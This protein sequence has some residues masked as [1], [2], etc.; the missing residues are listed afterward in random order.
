[1]TVMSRTVR[2]QPVTRE[3]VRRVAQWLDDPDVADSWYGKNLDG[4]PIH[5]GYQPKEMVDAPTDAWAEKFLGEQRRIYS[6]YVDGEGH[7]GEVQIEMEEPLRN[8]QVFV[9]LGRKDL[10][11][12][13]YGSTAMARALGIAFGDLGMHRV[14]ADVPEYNEPA[15]R[16]CKQIGFELEGRMRGT[17]FKDGKWY[18]SVVMGM[19]VD[20]YQRRK[21]SR[22][23][24]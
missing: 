6:I 23:L 1:M 9:L 18:D 15:T 5:I 12:H 2:L 19:L 22:R 3:D 10:W 17:R 13:G 11:H 16:M 14:W 20:E 4:I 21:A 24:P 7:I 8:A